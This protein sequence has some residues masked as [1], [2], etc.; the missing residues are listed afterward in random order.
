MCN[1]LWKKINIFAF[2]KFFFI[3]V[4]GNSNEYDIEFFYNL[5]YLSGYWIDNDSCCSHYSQKE[6]SAQK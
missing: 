5:P 1:D 4:Q 2:E 3:E 6:W